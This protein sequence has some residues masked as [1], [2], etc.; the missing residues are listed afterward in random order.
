MTLRFL[1]FLSRDLVGR[2]SRGFR[3]LRGFGTTY[4]SSCCTSFSSF[5]VHKFE[6]F[7]KFLFDSNES[8]SVAQIPAI[9]RFEFM[10]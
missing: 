9:E 3:G 8:S 4:L 2:F 7:G 5:L 10:R 6:A 1:D